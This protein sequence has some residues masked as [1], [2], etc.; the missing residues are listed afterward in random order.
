MSL[1]KLQAV[2]E[3]FAN[4]FNQSNLNATGTAA[5]QAAFDH[6]TLSEAFSESHPKAANTEQSF[7][8]FDYEALTGIFSETPT[9]T[10]PTSFD[11]EFPEMLS[12]RPPRSSNTQPPRPGFD[13]Q[14]FADLLSE[15]PPVSTNTRPPQPSFDHQALAE[16]LTELSADP[17]SPQMSPPG[18]DT[19]P[20]S[21]PVPGQF[22]HEEPKAKA[23]AVAP[24]TNAENVR[25][26]PRARSLLARLHHLF[27][28]R[29]EALLSDVEKEPP[30]APS[31]SGQP[32][33][34]EPMA[35]AIS[36]NAADALPRPADALLEDLPSLSF[37]QEPKS[38]H[39]DGQP[40]KGK[41]DVSVVAIAPPANT[42]SAWPLQET[43]LP[44][45][46]SAP[47]SIDRE[48][49]PPTFE[50]ES[51]TPT[52]AGRLGNVDQDIPAVAVGAPAEAEN[53][54]QQAKSLLVETVSP[55]SSIIEPPDPVFG[56]G[57]G[58]IPPGWLDLEKGKRGEKPDVEQVQRPLTEL[59]SRFSPSATLP[60][61]PQPVLSGQLVNLAPPEEI[62]PA[63]A[64]ADIESAWS[65]PARSPLPEL[66]PLISIDTETPS[67]QTEPSSQTLS[68][69][70][71]H[72]ASA[73]STVAHSALTHVGS[74]QP[75]RLRSLLAEI[76]P[77]IHSP[78]STST[79]PQ[80]F[81]FEKN[82]SAII[83]S[84]QPKHAE[85]A[86]EFVAAA[87]LPDAEAA[88]PQQ[89]KLL[90][91]ALPPSRSSFERKASP[92][93]FAGE[94][95]KVEPAV[96]TVAATPSANAVAA[97]QSESL[98][99]TDLSAPA[100]ANTKSSSPNFEQNLPPRSLSGQTDDVIPPVNSVWVAHP[101]GA[102]VAL[103]RHASSLL[104]ALDVLNAKSSPPLLQKEPSRSTVASQQVDAVMSVEAI[105]HPTDAE[106]AFPRQTKSLQTEMP[107]LVS[108]DA[109]PSSP[110]F[111]KEPL[112]R[113][114]FYQPS[115]VALTAETVA[116]A[117]PAVT[118][119]AVTR[120]E[121]AKSLL[122]EL[123]LNTAI[124]LRWVMRDIRS[125]RTKFSPV[126]ANDLA[127]LMDLGLVENRE[128]LPRLTGLGVLALD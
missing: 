103:P 21:A 64:S 84:H 119:S 97:Q 115:D 29:E 37:E 12:E 105:A 107:A 56:K 14:A 34:P 42:A 19:D 117:P 22:D 3:A 114:A 109:K 60:L 71:E 65:Q 89:D 63:A 66:P 1:D 118:E 94:L 91:A 41:P 13:D 40:G 46:I 57:G 78:D 9:E 47:I 18:Y 11:P 58:P 88:R 70:V 72:T 15:P 53:A 127:A 108:T 25:E 104:S 44:S 113:P 5:P 45:E 112:G 85:P 100:S 7:A 106:R 93:I 67:F 124:H 125:K 4:V 81:I 49:S 76:A 116:V 86:V 54:R 30:L 52:V 50:R 33:T 74:T 59:P 8:R 98:P 36:T 69:P 111:Q 48:P 102:E 32:H 31:L 121:Q 83:E 77:K 51:S 87:P 96:E 28:T 80:P 126:S 26:P 92:A 110:I 38:P 23:F 120:A 62:V 79:K 55:S 75:Q 16:M 128:G 43:S 10:S 122:A 6:E 123:D 2:H 61:P 95:D 20:S 101:T 99:L 73:A 90:L 68:R 39:L 24:P 82:S 35:R 27:S 17:I